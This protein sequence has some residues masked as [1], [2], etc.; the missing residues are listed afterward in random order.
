VR[1]FGPACLALNFALG[2]GA[3]NPIRLWRAYRAQRSRERILRGVR[4]VLVASRHM[5]AEVRRQGVAADRVVLAPLYPFAVSPLPRAPEP[6]PLT[7]R[8]LMAGRFTNL[9]GGDLLLAAVP[10]ASERLGRR[11]TVCFSGEGPEEA[12]WKALAA[13][14]GVDAEFVGWSDAERLARLRAEADLLAVP[15]VWPEPFG[16]VG[17]EAGCD[18]LP[19][20]GF[21]VG[22]I[23]DWLVPGRSG[24]SAPAPPTAA[25]LAEA[26]VRAL[27]DPA[28]HHRLRVGAWEIA[29]TFTRAR[30]LDTLEA[31]LRGGRAAARRSAEAVPVP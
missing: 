23:P 29:Q 15:S 10:Q 20:V 14:F 22:G 24:E 21:A 1:P 7:G 4:A 13:R 30:H 8:L 5:A 19:A 6:R 25:G 12:R 16:L 3:R 18:G 9:K 17:I 26:I 31:A 2:C 11:L 27:A 28:H